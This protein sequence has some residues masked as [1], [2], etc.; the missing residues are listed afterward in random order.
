MDFGKL[1]T[2]DHIDFSLPAEP[3][4]NREVLSTFCTHPPQLKAYIGCTGWSMKAWTGI[5][6][7]KGAKP[8]EYLFHYGRQ[9]NTIEHNTTH[10]SIPQPETVQKWYDAVPDDF[11][12]CPKIPQLI[13]H[14]KHLGL[15]NDLLQR[16]CDAIEVLHDKLGACFLQL[17]PYVGPD[18]LPLLQA[19]LS[20]FPKSIPLAL[21]F[22][23]PD[24]F[25]DPDRFRKLTGLLRSQQT[26]M[27]ITDVAGRRDVLHM[28][29]TSYFT[30]IRFVGNDLHPSD[31]SRLDAWAGRIR[32]WA[33]QGL[34]EAYIFTHEPDNLR[35]PEAAAYCFDQL[36]ADPFIQGRG[37]QKIIQPTLF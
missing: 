34:R 31:F 14:S 12:F 2:I 13:S 5:Y 18:R 26:G 28:A 4:G 21:E 30:M 1:P 22:R 29:I 8:G 33:S 23:H 37:P 9:F 25:N 11:K 35:A 24:W 10:Y 7:P 16:F 36:K 15:D 32:D 17:P 6:Y 27:V 19:F 20:Q 3:E